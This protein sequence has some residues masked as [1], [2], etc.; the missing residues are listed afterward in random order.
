MKVTT[1]NNR[2]KHKLGIEFSKAENCPMW[3]QQVLKKSEM[4]EYC[5]DV[6]GCY[7]LRPWSYA[8]WERIQASLDAKF[9][10]HGVEN[11]YFPMFVTKA[12]LEK[13]KSHVEGFKAEVAWVTRSG[14]TDLQEPIAIRPTSETIMYPYYQKWIRSHRDLPLKLNQWTN[15]VR[16]EF[17]DPTPFIRTREFLWQEGHTAHATLAEADK[18]V[19]D[20]L[21]VYRQTYEDLLAVPVIKG[22]KSE[23][24]K[25][26]G[27]IYTTSVETVIPSNGRGVQAATSHNLGQ[28]FSKMFDIYFENEKCEKELAWQTSWGFTTRSIGIM[29]LMHGDDKGLIL[30]PK[31]APIQVVMVPIHYT[32]EERD[33]LLAKMKELEQELV[34]AGIRT[35][36]DDRTVYRP[37]WKFNYWELKGVPLR[38]EFGMKDYKAS[39][40]TV[41]RRDSGEK[42]SIKWEELSKAIPELLGRFHIDLLDRA[43][44]GMNQAI[45]KSNN[46]DDFIK[47]VNQRKSCLTPWCKTPECE[48]KIKALSKIEAKK[49]VEI[50]PSAMTGSVKTLNIPFDSEPIQAGEKCFACGGAAVC[51]AIWGRSY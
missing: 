16:W 51:R 47:N 26:P 39:S 30:P 42:K 31:V 45:L 38:I 40:V 7:V 32:N 15:I 21:E 24:E 19:Q 37:G 46:M 23:E 2:E 29:I 10:E 1:F 18:M 50:D 33:K 27:A 34:K 44:K 43:K 5:N 9:K 13:E 6:S 14:D 17:K 41:V 35:K 28:N 20:M 3:Y 48:Q 22:I 4:I 11:A 49:Y 25:F 12:A 36:I 8:I